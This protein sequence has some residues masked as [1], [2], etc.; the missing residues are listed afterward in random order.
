MKGLS[1]AAFPPE[2]I[3]IMTTAFEA[4]VATLPEPVHSSHVAI[5]AESILRTASTGE[6]DAVI[7]ERIA[8]MELRLA[9]RR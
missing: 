8:L 7:L 3:E 9:Q 2:V 4:A 1:N 6:R 5:I